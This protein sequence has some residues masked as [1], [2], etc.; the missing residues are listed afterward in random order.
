MLVVDKS[1]SVVWSITLPLR[2]DPT[3]QRLEFL[4]QPVGWTNITN[5][6]LL[7]V[8]I[9]ISLKETKYVEVLRRP[10]GYTY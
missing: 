1:S 7:V 6:M 3:E 8:K 2:Q 10:T 4:T 9:A 5:T